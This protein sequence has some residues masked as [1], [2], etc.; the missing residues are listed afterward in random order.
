MTPT[1]DQLLAPT[2]GGQTYSIQDVLSAIGGQ[3]NP[4][5]AATPRKGQTV[6]DVLASLN[7]QSPYYVAPSEYGAERFIPENVTPTQTFTPAPFDFT[8]EQVKYAN[9]LVGM[10]Y[11][12][13]RAI[14]E[15]G[16]GQKLGSLAGSVY[17][18]TLLPVFGG[19]IGGT[20]GGALG[21]M[22][23]DLF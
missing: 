1:I 5:T 12:P 18:N 15:A 23:D 17:G 13:Q 20:L 19:M 8:A 6:D 9:Q 21:G 10:G 2:S 11:S 14:E 22:L 3:Y 16:L 4:E 7:T